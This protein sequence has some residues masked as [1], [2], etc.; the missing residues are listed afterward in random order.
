MWEKI[1]RLVFCEENSEVD[2]V[3]FDG[4]ERNDSEVFSRKSDEY[5]IKGIEEISN[6][7]CA[8]YKQYRNYN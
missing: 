4:V 1:K 2:L 6:R 3:V 7:V 8:L 5:F